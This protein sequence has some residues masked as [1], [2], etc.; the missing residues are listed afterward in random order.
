MG[1]LVDEKLN[2]SQQCSLGA[3][4]AN[5]ARAASKVAW[6]AGRGRPFYPLLHSAE[7]HWESFLHLWGPHHRTDMDLLEWGQWRP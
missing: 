4:K 7:T 1:V 6:A 2:M 5:R 3:Q